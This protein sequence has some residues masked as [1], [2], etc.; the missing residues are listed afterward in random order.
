MEVKGDFDVKEN[1]RVADNAKFDAGM[2]APYLEILDEKGYALAGG[3]FT[4]GDWRTRDL[5]TLID[6][7]FATSVSL[8]TIPGAGGQ[9]VIPAGEYYVDAS[10]PAFSVDEHQTRLADVTDAAGSLGDLVIGGTSE[11]AADA[12]QWLDS[13]G[14]GMQAASSSQSRSF[15]TGRFTVTRSTTLELQHRCASTQTNDG[16]G[17]ASGFNPFYQTYSIVKMWQVRDDT[18]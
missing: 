7:D 13:N 12:A 8:A 14:L 1:L 10:A 5:T 17:S 2:D 15:V 16:L 9:F 3:T 4:E 18:V 6:N 11:Y